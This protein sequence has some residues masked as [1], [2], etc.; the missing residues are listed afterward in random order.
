MPGNMPAL[1]RFQPAL[2]Q[3]RCAAS[4]TQLTLQALQDTWGLLAVISR[5]A[6]SKIHKQL[7]IF[8]NNNSNN[9]SSSNV[10]QVVR[11]IC[12][13]LSPS[14]SVVL[15]REAAR[16]TYT[17]DR[18]K[19]PRLTKM[20]QLNSFAACCN[21]VAERLSGQ[22]LVRLGAAPATRAGAGAACKADL[23]LGRLYFLP[24]HAWQK[25][26][27]PCHYRGAYYP[28]PADI[29]R[30]PSTYS[31]KPCMTTTTVHQS[32]IV[33]SSNSRFSQRHDVHC[34]LLTL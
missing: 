34:Q 25:H 11:L 6:I 5:Y 16:K 33:H 8:N 2:L 26:H 17:W 27:L 21:A 29:M 4:T 18:T 14:T 24:S 32:L 19:R 13:Q 15:G 22:Y 3:T 10:R 20:S 9:S 1:V 28:Y 30:R 23:L 7:R 12:W 31:L